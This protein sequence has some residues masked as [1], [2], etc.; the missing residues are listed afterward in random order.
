[1][2]IY[3]ILYGIAITLLCWFI[4]TSCYKKFDPITYA[5]P[6]TINGY[7]AASEIASSNLVAY[8]A[9][10]GSLIDSVS[11]NVGTNTGTSFTTTGFKNSAL[12]G[13]A[14]GYVLTDPSSALSSLTSF[15]VSEWVNTSPP[16]SGII[17][18]FSL[19]NKNTF[20][21]NIELFVENGS[22]NANGKLRLHVSKNGSDFTYATDNI[23]NLFN[24][25]VNITYTYDQTTN[26]FTLYINGS[27]V[28]SGT[29]GTLT[30][31]LVFTNVGK[32]VFGTVQFQTNPSQT[33]AS[34]SQSWASFLTG[35]IDEVRVYNKVLTPTEINSLVVLQGK[36]K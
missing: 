4:L 25:W 13:A 6:F 22:S 12:Q 32:V 24:G 31:P 27:K 29:A 35:Q 10:D 3:K 23:Q 2:K 7:S 21:G 16:S 33:S 15:T 26:Q 14:N 17:G 1:M 28:S 36:G 30:G 20:W 11:N 5:P 9:F 8:W 34:T 19:V 18:L